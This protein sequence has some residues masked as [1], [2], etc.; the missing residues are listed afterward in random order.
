NHLLVSTLK[1]GSAPFNIFSLSGMIF[2]ESLSL[3]PSAFLMLSPAFRNMDP[4]LEEAAL[5]S[6]GSVWFMIR[7][8]LFPL[9]T[10]AIL[11]TFVFLL[12]VGFVVFDVPGTIG[13]P[14]GIFTLSSHI[15]YLARDAAG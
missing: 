1:L 15:Y 4:T 9:L 10:P 8:V 13:M 14:A 5:T 11:S 6:G 12:I 2:V 7:R 3:V